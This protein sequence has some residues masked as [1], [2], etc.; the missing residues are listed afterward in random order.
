MGGMRD[1][2]RK[3]LIQNRIY[4]PIHWELSNIHSISENAKEIYNNVLSLV[5]DQ[6][7]D[8]SEIRYFIEKINEFRV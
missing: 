2:F 3:Y 4:C 6:R 1:E 5:C 7:Y 8:E